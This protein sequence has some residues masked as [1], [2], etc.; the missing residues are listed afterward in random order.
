[1]LDPSAKA[2]CRTQA[3]AYLSPKEIRD[4]SWSIKQPN[5]QKCRMTKPKRTYKPKPTPAPYP[6]TIQVLCSEARVSEIIRELVKLGAE[7]K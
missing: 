2:D 1:M 5:L 4:E 6:S 3:R 7:T